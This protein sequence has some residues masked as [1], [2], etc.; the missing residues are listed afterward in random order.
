MAD[1]R[2]AIHM[3]DSDKIIAVS[4]NSKNFP[5]RSPI[6]ILRQMAL[7]QKYHTGTASTKNTQN[8]LNI[9]DKHSK[10]EQ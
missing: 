10:L 5:D 1:S 6:P 9:S 8:W 3:A 2:P 4:F 7:P